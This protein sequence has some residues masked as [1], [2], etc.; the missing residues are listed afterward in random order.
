MGKKMDQQLD[1]GSK[2]TAG[3]HVD[4]MGYGSVAR[5]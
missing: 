5:S 2:M 1:N 3:Y 4:L